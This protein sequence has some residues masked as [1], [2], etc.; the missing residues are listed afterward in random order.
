MAYRHTFLIKVVN[1]SGVLLE[2]FSINLQFKLIMTKVILRLAEHEH[3]PWHLILIKN[4]TK[5]LI[6]YVFF[7]KAT[8]T[9]FLWDI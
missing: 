4:K 1:L 3:L 5:F 9:Q 2:F 8:L 6:K 7:K